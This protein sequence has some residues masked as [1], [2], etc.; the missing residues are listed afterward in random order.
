MGKLK[1]IL[2]CGVV[3]LAFG[4]NAA[5][6][7]G[8]DAQVFLQEE[9]TSQFS[10]TLASFVTSLATGEQTAVSVSNPLA[11]PQVEGVDF[12]GF[13]AGGDTEGPVWAFCYNAIEQ[14]QVYVYNSSVDPV[15]GGLDGDGML[16][17]GATWTVYV[18][19]ILATQGF[20]PA[21]DNFVGY[22][23]FV[24]E[25]DA[26]VGTY[27]NILGSVNSQQSFAM[28]ADFTGVPITVSTTAP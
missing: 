6:A 10:A 27:V 28:Q 4:V 15:G 20:D 7:R 12:T 13:P 25:F 2:I 21:A 19:D 22:C 18:H 3:L 16:V 24:G 26:I 9:G 11:T 14:G 8:S 23:Y 5:A 17:P 1:W